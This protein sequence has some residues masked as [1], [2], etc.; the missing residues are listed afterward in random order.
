MAYPSSP[1]SVQHVTCTDYQVYTSISQTPNYDPTCGYTVAFGPQGFL[2]S[3]AD[4]YWIQA[5]WGEPVMNQADCEDSHTWGTAWGYRCL[6][7]HCTEGDWERIGFETTRRG[8]WNS[9]YNTCQLDVNI[10]AGAADYQT[11][12]GQSLA[13]R[14]SGTNKV[15]KHAKVHIYVSRNTGGC[16]TATAPTPPQTPVPVA[17]RPRRRRS[18]SRQGPS[19][20]AALTHCRSA[21]ASS[22][23]YCQWRNR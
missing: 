10:H 7:A 19:G 13:S 15:L 4:S 6:A 5:D 2:M 17:Q 8:H 3:P 22:S 1:V 18:P 23:A 21:S 11:I 9:T 14:G 20:N 16:V 12:R